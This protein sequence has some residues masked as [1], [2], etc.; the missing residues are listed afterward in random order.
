MRCLCSEKCICGTPEIR[1][2]PDVEAFATKIYEWETE[3]VR[4]RLKFLGR[5]PDERHL[6]KSN[7]KGSL[8][9]RKILWNLLKLLASCEA[10]P[11]SESLKKVTCPY[12]TH[13]H[14]AI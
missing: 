7:N 5:D 11:T 2:D 3:R 12:S 14:T 4:T 6:R 8:S 9:L 1:I 10:E 13:I